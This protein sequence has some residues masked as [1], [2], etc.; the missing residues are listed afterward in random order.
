MRCD[1]C[2]NSRPVLSGNGWHSICC[3][4]VMAMSLCLTGEKDEFVENHMRKDGEG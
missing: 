2:L 4:P 1:K 3:L